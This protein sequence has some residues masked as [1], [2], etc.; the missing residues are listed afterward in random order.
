[1]M[2]R[3]LTNAASTLM[4]Y[5]QRPLT[6]FYY[7]LRSQTNQSTDVAEIITIHLLLL[8]LITNIEITTDLNYSCVKCPI[9]VCV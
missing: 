9:R 7:F 1:M 6:R 5:I 3:H 2:L 8:L 4:S